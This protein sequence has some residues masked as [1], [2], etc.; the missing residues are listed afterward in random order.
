MLLDLALGLLHLLNRRHLPLHAALSVS[1]VAALAELRPFHVGMSDLL[2]SLPVFFEVQPFVV[3]EDGYALLLARVCITAARQLSF[4]SLARQ[5]C[6][7][8]IVRVVVSR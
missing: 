2:S 3:L 6:P 5:R 8:A 7:P 4:R 1:L